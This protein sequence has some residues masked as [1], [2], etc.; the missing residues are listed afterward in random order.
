M[1][2]TPANFTNHFVAHNDIASAF[3]ETG[4]GIRGGPKNPIDSMRFGEP[5]PECQGGFT[6]P[7]LYS[8][9]ATMGNS[10]DESLQTFMS[11]ALYTNNLTQKE[12]DELSAAGITQVIFHFLLQLMSCN[13]LVPMPLFGSLSTSTLLSG[14]S[15]AQYSSPPEGVQVPSSSAASY[16][17]TCLGSACDF[18]LQIFLHL[19]F[20]CHIN[21][22]QEKYLAIMV[23]QPPLYR[24]FNFLRPVAGLCMLNYLRR[25]D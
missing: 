24:C 14:D 25:K 5:F 4:A 12:V 7:T 2:P 15:C 21:G 18:Y 1:Q 19:Q 3:N 22:T 8:S 6:E 13:L 11:E 23:S 17:C 16:H 20:G 9:V 10:L